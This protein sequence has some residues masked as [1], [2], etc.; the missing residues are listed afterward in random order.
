MTRIAVVPGA[1][2]C[3]TAGYAAGK[4]TDADVM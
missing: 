2:E 1:S 4:N 3:I